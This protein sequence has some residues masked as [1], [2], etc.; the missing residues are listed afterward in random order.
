MSRNV[1]R[2]ACPRTRKCRAGVLDHPPP[3]CEPN[4]SRAFT[5]GG[6]EQ[7]AD[8][9]HP[10][11]I[12]TTHNAQRLMSEPVLGIIGGSGLYHMPRLENVEAVEL[13]TPFGP[14]SSTITLGTLNGVDLAFL[15]RH[16][17]GHTL[18]PSEVPYRANIY[19]MKIL[20]VERILSVSAVGSLREEYPPLDVV[21]PDQIFDRTKDRA[22][23]FFG[24]GLVAHVGFAHP[25]C[26]AFRKT[27]LTCAQNSPAKAHD[28]G[29]LVVMEG[30]MFSTIAESETYRRQGFS[31]VGMT[32]LPEAKL[33]REAELC[34]ATLA[35]VTDYDVWH[36]SHDSV[37]SDMVAANVSHNTEVAHG[38]IQDVV[39][40]LGSVGTCECSD[41]LAS[42]LL[43]SFDLV[44]ESTLQELE[45][46]IGKYYHPTA[47]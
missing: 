36:P 21:V 17:P 32:A 46:I 38:I 27:V 40:A 23:T 18:L 33:A 16:G 8:S 15:A 14:P 28:G 11:A 29:T 35:M 2:Y 19:A 4:A 43:T 25:F 42:A 37:T 31:L 30:P 12:R 6:P 3:T 5:T 44:P 24:G 26:P 9:Q 22:A 20:G 13:E 45:P 47:G 39:E 7:R 10:T 34:Y 41:A 1:V